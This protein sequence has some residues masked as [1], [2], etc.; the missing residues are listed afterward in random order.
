[1]DDG[2]RCIAVL[3]PDSF[4]LLRDIHWTFL[5]VGR[6]NMQSLDLPCAGAPHPAADPPS[7]SFLLGSDNGLVFTSLLSLGEELR[8]APRSSSR[9]TAQNK[10]LGQARHPHAQ[11][12]MRSPPSLRDTAVRQPCDRRLDRLLQQPPAPP[13][14]VDEDSR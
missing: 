1:M 5:N 11:G 8:A 6:N 10:L 12:A 3:S 14:A 2:N 13:D 9:R 7:R 4:R